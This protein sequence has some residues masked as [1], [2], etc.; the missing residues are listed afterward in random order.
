VGPATSDVSVP[1]VHTAEC[2]DH[3]MVYAVPLTFAW[4][5]TTSGSPSTF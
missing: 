5:E 2:H 4:R 1:P 3:T